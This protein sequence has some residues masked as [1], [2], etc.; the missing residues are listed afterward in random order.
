M[1]L[2]EENMTAEER[3]QLLDHL[4]ASTPLTFERAALLA[5]YR[6]AS[7][8]RTAARAG[9]LVVQRHSER[10]MLILAGDLRA[11]LQNV[12]ERGT[13]RGQPRQKTGDTGE[14]VE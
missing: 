7:S 6:S 11:Y 14:T 5:N 13:A 12:H 8:L 1:P 9:K 10:L 4:P 3:R 2:E